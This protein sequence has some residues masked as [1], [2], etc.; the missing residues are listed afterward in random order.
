MNINA[1]GGNNTLMTELNRNVPD[2]TAGFVKHGSDRMANSVGCG[3]R[4][5]ASFCQSV[6]NSVRTVER[7][8]RLTVNRSNN[9]ILSDRGTENF[10]K[11]FVAELFFS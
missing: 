6:K 8:V 5:T 9:V 4:Q 2:F 3:V 11:L 10:V 7:A 1:F